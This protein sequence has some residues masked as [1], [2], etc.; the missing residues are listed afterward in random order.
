L[1]NLKIRK[2]R[3][4]PTTK[5][6][7]SKSSNRKMT[8]FPTSKVDQNPSR[9]R[10]ERRKW[11]LNDLT[12]TFLNWLLKKK[13]RNCRESRR[14]DTT[15][16]TSTWK[17]SESRKRRKR[18]IRCR[19]TRPTTENAKSRRKFGRRRCPLCRR[20][21]RKEIVLSI[22]DHNQGT[23]TTTLLSLSFMVTYLL[24]TQNILLFNF[25]WWLECQLKFSNFG[26]I[27][28]VLN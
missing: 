16:R 4:R 1:K 19:R 24:H 17:S 14:C 23:I 25:C 8:F 21:K 3:R 20:S 13:K 18:R 22:F 5:S 11:R 12:E 15:A 10:K 9:K 2:C 6:F 26:W 7:H 27:Y 28:L